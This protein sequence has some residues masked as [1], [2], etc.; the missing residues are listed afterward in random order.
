MTDQNAYD[1]CFW[2]SGVQS[3]SFI[4]NMSESRFAI[5]GPSTVYHLRGTKSFG[6]MALL[7]TKWL[8]QHFHNGKSRYKFKI[9]KDGLRIVV[10]DYHAVDLVIPWEILLSIVKKRP[11]DN[12]S[13][14]SDT[15]LQAQ[16]EKENSTELLDPSLAKKQCEIHAEAEHCEEKA[17][18]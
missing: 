5:V 15:D 11:D 3:R 10:T 6:A 13:Q 1:F 9:E 18:S 16:E 7:L 17:W 4:D 12:S 2:K 14:D 8:V